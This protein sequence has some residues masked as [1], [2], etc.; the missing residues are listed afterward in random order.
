[1]V[2]IMLWTTAPKDV[3]VWGSKVSAVYAWTTKVRPTW[4]NWVL[5]TETNLR[6]SNY[7]LFSRETTSWKW[8]Y[9]RTL[10][11]IQNDGTNWYWKD[12]NWTPCYLRLR[13]NYPN[14]MTI[15]TWKT[16]RQ[17]KVVMDYLYNTASAGSN[18]NCYCWMINR[19]ASYSSNYPWCWFH[20]EHNCRLNWWTG[21]VVCRAEAIINVNTMVWTVDIYNKSTD[22]L[23]ATSSWNIPTGTYST[24]CFEG[25]C[26]WGVMWY[27]WAETRFGDVHIYYTDI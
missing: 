14:L 11:T 6:N 13:S 25:D 2:W 20:Q 26:R 19:D 9:S 27:G 3:Y 16:N 4:P 24:D 12:R 8:Q 22:V 23:I 10:A 5:Y 17:I 1:M 15:P 21:G 18:S 7:W